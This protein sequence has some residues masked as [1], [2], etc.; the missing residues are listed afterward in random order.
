MLETVIT[1]SEVESNPAANAEEFVTLAD[2]Q[3]AL[4]GGGSGIAQLD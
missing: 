4:I 1:T 2:M 3:L